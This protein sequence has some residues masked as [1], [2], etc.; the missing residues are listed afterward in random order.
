MPQVAPFIPA[1][2]GAAGTLYSVNAAKK[3]ADAQ[4]NALTGATDAHTA[5]NDEALALQ[6]FMFDAQME[7]QMPWYEA[8]SWALGEMRSGIESGK[9]D[10]GE[11]EFTFD[12]SDPSYK[13]RFDQGEQAVNRGAVNRGGML[14]GRAAKELTRYGQGMAST[15]YQNE[16]NR[17]LTTH[18]T[19]A[20]RLINDY[21]MYA[22]MSN[23]GRLAANQ[24]GVF[25]QNYAN[26][27]G[28]LILNNGQNQ[29]NM[30]Y[31]MGGINAAQQGAYS[32]A[33][34]NLG[35]DIIYYGNSQGWFNPKTSYTNPYD[36]DE[37]EGMETI[38]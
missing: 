36:N 27:G 22:G 32:N 26:Q 12:E 5:A 7:M 19:N 10:P 14:S 1:I 33:F 16:F 4:R 34:N 13:W 35:R 21:N 11:F 25:G 8:G 17:D 6:K 29:A 3:A 15:E 9:W 23:T 30:L 38:G 2:I 31:G 37:Y 18:Q 24:I 28:N 20:N